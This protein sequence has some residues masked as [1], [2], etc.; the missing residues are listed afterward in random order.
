MT[1]SSGSAL[2]ALR[3]KRGLR[4]I[5]IRAPQ[6]LDWLS[7]PPAKCLRIR[8]LRERLDRNVLNPLLSVPESTRRTTKNPAFNDIRIHGFAVQFGYPTARR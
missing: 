3:A 2:G 5:R 1:A 6:K 8:E 7:G 4:K